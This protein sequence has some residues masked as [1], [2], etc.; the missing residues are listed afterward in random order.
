MSWN[1][2]S[3]GQRDDERDH[4]GG[5]PAGHASQSVRTARTVAKHATDAQDCR[6]LLEMLGLRLDVLKAEKPPARWAPP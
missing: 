6:L 2:P 3:R 1:M 4:G 5:S